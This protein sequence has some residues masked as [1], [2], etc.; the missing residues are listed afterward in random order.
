M[1]KLSKEAQRSVKMHGGYRCKAPRVP[2]RFVVT[3]DQAVSG[4]NRLYIMSFIRG[5]NEGEAWKDVNGGNRVTVKGGSCWLYA[6]PIGDGRGELLMD[7]NGFRKV[8]L[9]VPAD[10][11]ENGFDFTSDQSDALGF[12]IGPGFPSTCPV[13]M[14]K[15]LKAG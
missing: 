2:F 11:T 9:I 1:P 7:L 4:Y 14:K 15:Y 5:L 8:G 13:H 10:Q 12:W 6:T 3:D